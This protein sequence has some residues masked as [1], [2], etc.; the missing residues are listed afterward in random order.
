MTGQSGN[1]SSGSGGGSSWQAAGASAFGAA[2]GNQFGGVS[3][4]KAR[5]LGRYAYVNAYKYGLRKTDKYQWRQA[6]NRGLTPQEY[7]G[8]PAPG[9]TGGGDSAAAT[10]G[11]AGAQEGM[12]RRQSAIDA[13]E[14]ALDRA[15]QLE[16]TRMQTDA[17]K[18]SADTAAG[19]TTGAAKIS[20]E[21]Q[22]YQAEIQSAIAQNRLT[23]DEKTYSTVLLPG[24]MAQ[25]DLTRKQAQKVVN[26]I[27][28][29]DP[30][31]VEAM[32]M[33]SMGTDNM[34]ATM[35]AQS[36]GVNKPSDILK[37]DVEKR[38]AIIAS[39]IAASSN[40]RKELE[41]LWTLISDNAKGF[42]GTFMPEFLGNVDTPGQETSKLG[43][44]LWQKRQDHASQQR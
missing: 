34:V 31:F 43:E 30:K 10:L 25:L 22:M 7:Y 3:G 18:Y 33:L 1:N 28:T 35:L 12:A 27:A 29:S 44:L 13:S 20:A 14:S 17:Q 8:S 15:T 23:F 16:I 11:N 21:A 24:A 26:D 5:R 38:K 4:A 32:K 6:Q 9:N 36:E 2:L 37:F 19:A 42:W 39:M 40:S 41:G